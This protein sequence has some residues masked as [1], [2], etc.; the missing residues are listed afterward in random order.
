MTISII[1]AL[2]EN[3]AIGKNNDLLCYISADLKRFKT[4]TTGH[5]ILMGRKTFES[6]PKGALPNRRNVVMT[7]DKNF[8][9][10]ACEIV[11]TINEAFNICMEAEYVFIIGGAQIYKLFIEHADKLFLTQIHHKFDADTYFPEFDLSKWSV[12]KKEDFEPDEKNKFSF[13]FI[14]YDKKS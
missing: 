5:T 7:R 11:H 1:A 6:L 8:K 4:L 13:S 10:N 14:D 3:N 12:V 9:C 2:D